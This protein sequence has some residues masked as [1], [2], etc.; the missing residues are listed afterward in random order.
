MLEKLTERLLIE[1][2]RRDWTGNKFCH[3]V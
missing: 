3:N 1:R 2:F